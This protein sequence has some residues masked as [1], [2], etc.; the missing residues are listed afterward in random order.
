MN[1]LS[2]YSL[3]LTIPALIGAGLLTY[4]YY[5]KSSQA[6]DWT[7]KQKKILAALR[8]FGIFILLFLLFGLIWE[9]ISYRKEKPLFITL[10][11]QSQ[12]IHNYKDSAQ[13]DKQITAFRNQ[14]KA[15]FGND[16]ELVELALGAQTVPF[17]N[18]LK[19][20]GKETDLAAGFKYIHD[21][22]FNRNIGGVTLISDGNATKGV[23]P[24]YEA[25]RLDLVPVFTLGIGD[26]ISKKDQL[27]RAINAN[28]VAFLSNEFP[29]EATV[30]FVKI[31]KGAARVHLLQNGKKIQSKTVNC[32]NSNF[33][34]QTVLF[35]VKAAQKGFQRFT[36][37]VESRSGEFTL[38]NNQQSCYV[39]VLD[40][41]SSILFLSSAPHPDLAAIRNVLE[42]DKSTQI[43]A[44]LIQNYQLSKV[45]PNLVVWYENGNNSNPAL[46]VQLLREK[47]PV[48]LI[49]SPT[50]PNQVVQALVTGLKSPKGNQTETVYPTINSGFSAFSFTETCVAAMNVAPPME[51]RFGAYQLPAN[52]VVVLQ[53]RIGK[54]TKSDP[55]FFF[56]SSQQTKIGVLLGEGIWRWKLN[57]FMRTKNTDGFREFIQKTTQYL[58]V[59]QSSDPFRISFPKRFIETDEITLKADFYNAAM[60]LITTPQ[61]SFS[62]RK[63]GGGTSKTQFSPASNFYQLNLGNLAAGTYQWEAI[64]SNNGTKNKKSGTFVVEAIALEALTTSADFSVLNQ[65]ARQSDGQ[66]YPLGQSNKLID[67]LKSRSDIATV[68]FEDTSYR[69]LIDLTFI[70]VLIVLLFGAEWF[71][72]RWWGAY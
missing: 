33:Y 30:E 35:T 4:W 55:L 51:T 36:V 68:Q 58:T 52:A 16:F 60:E 1:Y 53:Q 12:S 27:I 26:T 21:T 50:T 57:E 72:R 62:Y 37:Q 54:I 67:Y 42:E 14:L 23:H 2:D 7:T 69:S 46:F 70:F 9:A 59:R 65:L 25:E 43:T 31:P 48:L 6:T 49:L 71:L 15:Q 22:Y 38:Q 45:V 44:D 32:N 19:A 13:V 61:I 47:I 18:Q 28:E 11:D 34:Q 3:W 40:N 66:F 5:F 63:K 8:G 64:A 24:M 39:E 20:N 41:K 56:A 29:I 10:I 17:E